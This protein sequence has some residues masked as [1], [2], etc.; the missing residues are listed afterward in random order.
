MDEEHDGQARAGEHACRT[1]NIQVQTLELV[2][3]QGLLRNDICGQIEELFLVAFRVDLGLRADGTGWVI[4][5]F[6]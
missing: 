2:L 5:A 4:S 1:S 3:L 6:V